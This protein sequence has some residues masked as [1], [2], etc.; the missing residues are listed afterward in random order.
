[1]T[2]SQLTLMDRLIN[3]LQG[4]HADFRGRIHERFPHLTEYDLRLCIMIKANL[5]TKE[6]A[7]ILNITPDSAKKAKHRLR[8]KLK[9]NPDNS[10]DKFLSIN[11]N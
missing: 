4:K 7:T 9:M 11:Q 3:E 5:S 8:K 6:I 10:W 1:M 2:V